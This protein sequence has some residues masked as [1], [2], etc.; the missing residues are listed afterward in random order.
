MSE[1][2]ARQVLLAG[3]MF[4]FKTCEW[5]AKI[6]QARLQCCFLVYYSAQSLCCIMLVH[7][8]DKGCLYI[9]QKCTREKYRQ[10][11]QASQLS[12]V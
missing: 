10:D 9:G 11:K 4:A 5:E 12:A 2:D 8:M 3:Y 1:A 6:S 7:V